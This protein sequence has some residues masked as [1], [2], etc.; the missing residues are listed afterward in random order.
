MS[1]PKAIR[2]WDIFRANLGD[3]PNIKNALVGAVPNQRRMDVRDGHDCWLLVLSSTETN[4]ILGSTV[5]ACEI[6]PDHIQK[7]SPSPL[8][9]PVR[10]GDTGLGW[11]AAISVMTLA[12]IPRNCLV[13]LEGRLDPAG[14]R[15]ASLRGLEIMTGAEP[16]P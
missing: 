3:G 15:A 2:Q 4:E 16:W 8:N 14:L 12:S 9:L 6:V 11:P 13:A 5:L 10:P 1:I 7:L